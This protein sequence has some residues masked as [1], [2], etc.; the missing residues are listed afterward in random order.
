MKAVQVGFTV[1]AETKM[2]DLYELNIKFGAM[3]WELRN[4]RELAH[5]NK[6]LIKYNSG[7]LD[8]QQKV[9]AMVA[10]D[11]TDKQLKMIG[12]G[13]IFEKETDRSAQQLA[14]INWIHDNIDESVQQY[15]GV[16][17]TPIAPW[18]S[19]GFVILYFLSTSDV[20]HFEEMRKAFSTSKIMW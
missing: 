20:R 12:L 11:D 6:E 7:R 8:A 2:Y 13:D 18:D 1:I 10:M 4:I 14:V 5:N 15:G 17:V 16:C 19:P 9:L 3:E